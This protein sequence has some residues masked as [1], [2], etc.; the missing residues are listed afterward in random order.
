MGRDVC[1]HFRAD[2]WETPRCGRVRAI[3]DSGNHRTLW[4]GHRRRRYQGHIDATPRRKPRG[5]QL[6]ERDKECNTELSRLRAPVERLI[7][8]FKSWRILHTDYRRPYATYTDAFDA[9]RALFF[10]SISWGFV[11]WPGGISPP[12]SHRTVRNSL[13][14]HGSCCPGHQTRGTQ[15]THCH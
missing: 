13:P 15:L 8:H 12:G 7:A 3:T 1:V 14:L 2:A 11:G 5:G 10:F 9:A 6:S 4:W